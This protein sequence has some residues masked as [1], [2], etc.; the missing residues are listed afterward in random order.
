MLSGGVQGTPYSPTKSLIRTLKP[1]Y[2][3]IYFLAKVSMNAPFG[4]RPCET[5]AFFQASMISAGDASF[6]TSIVAAGVAAG[7]PDD[8]LTPELRPKSEDDVDAPFAAAAV[9]AAAAA[10]SAAAFATALSAGAFLS[11]TAESTLAAAAAAISSASPGKIIFVLCIS[12]YAW[13]SAATLFGA[14]T[15]LS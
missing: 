7:V 9:R 13:A 5:W 4:S 12:A 3:K 8:P 14:S 6:G 15:R 10:V 1:V 11:T 2:H